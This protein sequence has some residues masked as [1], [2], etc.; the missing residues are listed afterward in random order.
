M[1]YPGVNLIGDMLELLICFRTNKYV[2]L[3]DVMIRLDLE[4]V[5]N[6]VRFFI[7][8][9]E[10]LHCYRYTTILFCFSH[11]VLYYRPTHGTTVSQNWTPI[12]KCMIF[13]RK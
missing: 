11:G 13:R 9:D 4:K 5:C 10:N 6:R 3:A 7:R 12:E 2:L 1:I 8:M